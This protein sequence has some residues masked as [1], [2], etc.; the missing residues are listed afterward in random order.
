[1]V[2]PPGDEIN[3]QGQ[4]LDSPRIVLISLERRFCGVHRMVYRIAC[5]YDVQSL[6]VWCKVTC[7]MRLCVSVSE[8]FIHIVRFLWYRILLCFS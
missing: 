8:V 6:P 4:S 3:A 7:F 2:A 5:L 1:M